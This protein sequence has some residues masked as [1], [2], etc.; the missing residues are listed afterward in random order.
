MQYYNLTANVNINVFTH[1]EQ[2]TE[3]IIKVQPSFVFSLQYRTDPG[4]W[5]AAAALSRVMMPG[6]LTGGQR[7]ETTWDLWEKPSF[8][9]RQVETQTGWFS[10]GRNSYRPNNLSA[11]LNPEGA[12][13]EFQKEKTIPCLQENTGLFCVSIKL[14]KILCPE[15]ETIV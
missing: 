2:E 12:P 5:S 8:F 4:L 6:C 1:V 13:L 9:N 7:S 14:W 10:V 15:I 3:Y 11:G